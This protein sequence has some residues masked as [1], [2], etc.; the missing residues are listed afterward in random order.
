MAKKK[1]SEKAAN[2]ETSG[3]KTSDV[4]EGKLPRTLSEKKQKKDPV[5]GMLTG[6]R[7]ITESSDDAR[8]FYNQSRFGVITDNGK[9]EL[10]L[11]EALYLI[12]KGRLKLTSKRPENSNQT[13]G[14]A[15]SSSRTCGTVATSSKRP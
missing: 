10:S 15:T 7:I 12:E 4:L 3:G 1:A 5:I 11:L 2:A 9:V 8:D 14:F 6:E 13:S